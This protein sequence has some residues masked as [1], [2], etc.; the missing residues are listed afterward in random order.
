MACEVA[1]CASHP[2]TPH[3]RE[4]SC[5]FNDAPAWDCEC[6]CVKG[7]V[8]QE[9]GLAHALGDPCDRGLAGIGLS[10]AEWRRCPLARTSSHRSGFLTPAPSMF[11]GPGER[12]GNVAIKI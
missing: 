8:W 1:K 12:K 9:I 3:T 4:V 5:E 2:N 11:G 7:W 10:E 6:V